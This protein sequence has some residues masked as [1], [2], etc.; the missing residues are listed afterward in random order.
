MIIIK[1]NTKCY[2]MAIMEAIFNNDALYYNPFVS[3]EVEEHIK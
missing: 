3:N 2:L 1:I